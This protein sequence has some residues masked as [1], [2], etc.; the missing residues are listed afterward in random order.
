[1]CITCKAYRSLEIDLTT[2]AYIRD[3]FGGDRSGPN[4]CV[5]ATREGKGSFE[6]RG[7]LVALHQIGDAGDLNTFYNGVTLEDL[8]VVVDWFKTYGSA[9]RGM[10]DELKAMGFQGF[11]LSS[12]LEC[13]LIRELSNW[14]ESD[15][16]Q[17][18]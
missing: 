3:N 5:N 14:V 18:R 12:G 11:S 13:I 9:P 7:R 8:R 2:I 1:M 16:E 10:P 17:I 6:W 4:L 15:I